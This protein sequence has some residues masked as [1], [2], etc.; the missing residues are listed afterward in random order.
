[1]II[2][3]GPKTNFFDHCP[4]SPAFDL[5]FLFLLVVEELIVID[6]PDDRW[7]RFGCDLYQIQPHLIGPVPYDIGTK[8]TTFY[9]LAIHYAQFIQIVTYHTNFLTYYV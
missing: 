3:I 9:R 6:D 2:R 7:I 8:N 1:M 5:F 4:C